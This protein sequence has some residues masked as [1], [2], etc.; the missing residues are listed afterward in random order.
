VGAAEFEPETDNALMTPPST[1]GRTTTAG[2]CLTLGVGSLPIPLW[3]HEFADVFHLIVNELLYWSLV[4]VV[5]LYVIKV[6]RRPLS[7]I[8][9]RRLSL[10][11]AAAGFGVG[12]ATLAGLWLLYAIVLP[13]L[14]QSE[15]QP[16]NQLRSAPGWWLAASVVRAGVSEEVLFRGYPIERL[17]EWTRRRG[18]AFGV[19]LLVFSIAH[20]GSWGWT[21]LLIAG[22]GGL[23][24][25]ALYAWRR[26]LWTNILAHCL[27]DGLAVLP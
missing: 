4:A 24:L 6:E 2:L 25:T 9:I 8:G 20:I 19:P 23:M 22:F 1:T 16:I 18:I 13:I 3:D 27:V 7:S 21:H 12:V 11:D 15:A 10:A 17:Q 26:N 5:L 14:H